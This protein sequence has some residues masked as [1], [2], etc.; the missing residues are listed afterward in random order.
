MHQQVLGDLG[1]RQA[2]WAPF[3]NDC[4]L[5]NIEKTIKHGHK[6]SGYSHE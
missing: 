3:L 5:V 1:K 4:P 2:G 6:K